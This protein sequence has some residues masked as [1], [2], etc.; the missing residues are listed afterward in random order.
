L[1]SIFRRTFFSLTALLSILD[2]FDRASDGEGV[3]RR[4]LRSSSRLDPGFSVFGEDS[5]D[6]DEADDDASLSDRLLSDRL[7]SDRLLS[8]RL[9]CLVF[10]FL[11]FGA[12]DSD[13]PASRPP[14]LVSSSDR[15][16]DPP[17]DN[18]SEFDVPRGAPPLPESAT[19][20][21]VE[22]SVSAGAVLRV[23]FLRRRPR[24]VFAVV[25]ATLSVVSTAIVP[26][27]GKFDD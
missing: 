8:D 12:F 18:D 15:V 10:P 24:V 22:L 27:A 17:P 23:D 3:L 16:R 19:R 2:E 7:L 6:E 21:L 1:I 5:R 9:L 11:R 26:P 25:S 13:A 14:D 20:S 4:R